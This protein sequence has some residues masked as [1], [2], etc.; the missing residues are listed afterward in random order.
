[1]GEI[2]EPKLVLVTTPECKEYSVCN[3]FWMILKEIIKSLHSKSDSV[4]SIYRFIQ[5]RWLLCNLKIY[6][7]TLI[8]IY[9]SKFINFDILFLGMTSL[10]LS[11]YWLVITNNYPINNSI[12][13]NI[14]CYGIC[15]TYIIDTYYQC[16]YLCHQCLL[17]FNIIFTS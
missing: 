6:I 4:R 11:D 2:Q 7:K 17:S 3:I 15:H 12:H 14:I 13:T 10:Y 8:H 1:M 16:Y 5:V 9:R